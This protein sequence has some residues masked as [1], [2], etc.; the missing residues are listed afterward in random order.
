MGE[1]KEFNPPEQ[2]RWQTECPNCEAIHFT[3]WWEG[4]IG[5]PVCGSCGFSV[6]SQAI[7]EVGD[8]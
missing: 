4:K 6:E 8:E 7:V 3:I 2:D 1:V 5:T